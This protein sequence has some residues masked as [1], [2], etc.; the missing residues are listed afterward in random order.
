MC[1]F[2][3]IKIH[4][5]LRQKWSS[6]RKKAFISGTESNES[7]TIMPE[8]PSIDLLSIHFAGNTRGDIKTWQ[9][10]IKC[11]FIVKHMHLANFQYIVYTGKSLK[12]PSFYSQADHL[13]G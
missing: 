11:H 8:M 4:V 12:L 2:R 13:K 3:N 6:F 9:I 5:I 1:L 7:L 10:Q